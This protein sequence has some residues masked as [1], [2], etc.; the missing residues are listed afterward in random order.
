MSVKQSII[1][2][3]ISVDSNI[4]SNTGESEKSGSLVLYI[5]IRMKGK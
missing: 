5:N 2:S 4:E 3:K 1:V